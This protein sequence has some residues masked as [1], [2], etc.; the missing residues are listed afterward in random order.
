M[1]TAKQEVRKLLERVAEDASFEEI[2]YHIYVHQK[3]DRGLDDV[4]KGR[5][6]SQQEAEER[7]ARW[8]DAEDDAASNGPKPR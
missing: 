6:V 4:E 3:V 8:F 1:R 2:Q 5:V 7:M